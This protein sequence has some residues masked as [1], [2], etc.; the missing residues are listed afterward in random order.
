MPVDFQPESDQAI[1]FQPEETATAG[2]AALR[3]VTGPIPVPPEFDPTTLRKRY[4]GPYSGG[5]TSPYFPEQMQEAVS[6]IAAPYRAAGAVLGGI[7][8]DVS[9]LASDFLRRTGIN[10]AATAGEPM[11]NVPRIP[12]VPPLDVLAPKTG[13]AIEE[14]AGR[15]VSGFTEPGQAAL[16]PFA[17]LRP[18]QGLFG[19][20]AALQVPE[21]IQQL[22]Q[23]KGAPEVAG[24]TFEALANLGM[25]YGIGKHLAG[26][27]PPPA[28]G[29]E[30]DA[31][32][33]RGDK[34][35]GTQ[36][37]QEPQGSQAHRGGDVEQA[38]PG[39]T[40]PVETRKEGGPEVLLLNQASA[41]NR[42]L[43]IGHEVEVL[44]DFGPQDK[45]HIRVFRALPPNP[46][47]TPG[48]IQ[49]STAAF[50]KWLSKVPE[51]ERASAV[52]T[53]LAEEGI[54]STVTPEQ[55]L[56]YLQTLSPAEVALGKKLYLGDRTAEEAGLTPA[57]LGH[58]LL[59]QRLQR[60]L[61]MRPTELA[62]VA[63][64]ERWSRASLEFISRMIGKVRGLL[65]TDAAK[66]G[67]K[68]VNGLLDTYQRNIASLTGEKL[69]AA[70][71][72]DPH[73]GQV[74]AGQHHPAIMEALGKEGFE[75][76]ESRNTPDF[77]FSTNLRPFVSRTEAAGIAEGSGQKLE[78]FDVND[79]EQ[80]QPHSN[81]VA[82]PSDPEKP[83]SEQ[84][85]PPDT[86][87]EMP[88]LIRRKEDLP[89][90]I[91]GDKLVTVEREDG[92]RYVAA[93]GGKHWDLSFMGRGKVPSIAVPVNDSW[94]HGVLPKG[95]KV[96]E[97]GGESALKQAEERGGS[98]A[99][100]R[101]KADKEHP[102]LYLPPAGPEAA[103]GPRPGL[104]QATPDAVH[105]EGYGVLTQATDAATEEHLAGK[106]PSPPSFAEFSKQ[107]QLTFGEMN[108]AALA[109]AWA[110]T[111]WNRLQNASGETL[112][113]LRAALDMRH[114]LGTRDI[115]NPAHVPQRTPELSV[116]PGSFP[117]L[118]EEAR[119][120]REST[121]EARAMRIS[122]D[123]YRNNV[124]AQ[125]GEK[126]IA[127]SAKA[128]N[129]TRKEITPEDVA[130]GAKSVRPAFN[131]IGPDERANPGLLGTVLTDDARQM[132]IKVSATKRLTVLQN[133]STGKVEMVSTYRDP[134]RGAVLMDPDSPGRT[135]SPLASILK[136]WRPVVSVLLTEPVKDFQQSFSS[137][138]DFEDR[139]GSAA[140]SARQAGAN[141][142][143]PQT[144]F[145]PPQESPNA[146]ASRVPITEPEARA[147]LS[148]VLEEG[149]T[150][151]SPEDAKLALQSL[152]STT[153]K[154]RLAISGLKKL[155]A[156][157][158]AANP[159]ETAEGL[160]NKLAQT[161]YDNHKAATSTE[162]FQRRTMESGRPPTVP[163]PGAVPQ[164]AR[165]A[166]RA[167]DQA[168]QARIARALSGQGSEADVLEAAG[169]QSPADLDNVPAMIRRTAEATAQEVKLVY[170][171]V[172]DILRA[173]TVSHQ[174]SAAADAADNV[175][176]NT[177]RRAEFGIRLQSVHRPGSTLK[178]WFTAWQH[179]NPDVLAAA[180]VIVEAQGVMDSGAIHIG[181]VRAA[182]PGFR[183]KVA[184]GRAQA[185]VMAKSQSFRERRIG[186]AWLRACDQYDRELNYADA[187]LQDPDLKLTAGR[188]KLALDAQYNLERSAGY[189]LAKDPTYVPHR[190]DVELW[191]GRSIAFQ[192]GK[193]L[194]LKFR[195]AKRFKT[196]YDAIEQGPYL[197]VTR[198]SASLVS[199]RIR[200]GTQ[201]MLRDAWRK[202]LE[203]V[204]LPNGRPLAVRPVRRTATTWGSP[205]SAYVAIPQGGG[206][207]P[208]LI[209]HEDFESLIRNLTGR[210]VIHDWALTHGA[211]NIS[212]NLKHTL[213]MGD[214]FHLGR[215]VYYA[216]GIQ[217]TLTPKSKGAW[218]ALE[219]EPRDAADAIQRGVISRSDAAWAN[220]P[221]KFGSQ[222][223]NRRTLARMFESEAGLNIG[224]IQ[225]A[226]Y[227]DLATKLSP[228]AGPIRR[229]FVAVTDPSVGRYN[230]FLFDR[231]SRGLMLESAVRQF[232]EQ[233]KANPD[234]DPRLLMGDIA[235][236]VNVFFGNIGRQGWFKGAWQQDL[237]RMFLLAPQW[238]EGLIK[239]EAT[240]YT[241][242]GGTVA[243]AFGANY[244]QGLPALGTIGTGM[245]RGL[246]FMFALTQAVNLLTR[247]KPTWE[248]PE[249][250]HRFDAWIPGW[251]SDS[252][253]FWLSPLALFNEIT[254][255][256]YR[257]VEDKPKWT[258]AIDQIAGNKESP[259]VRGAI[260][261]WTSRSPTG[262]YLTTA[263]S[264]IG[265]TLEQL[266]PVP[267]TFS[268][269]A[270][271][272]AH[273]A[274]PG[275]VQANLPG[276]VQRQVFSTIGLKVEPARSPLQEAQ[277]LARDFA[278]SQKHFD[279]IHQEDTDQP[280]YSRLRSAVRAGDEAAAWKVLDQLRAH[281]KK[282]ADILKAMLA[283]RDRP[284]TWSRQAE[285]DF[286]YSLTPEQREVL[287]EATYQKMREY[288]AF[289]QMYQNQPAK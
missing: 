24:R 32:A 107:M 251:G 6:T 256:V 204:I 266:A 223:I 109:D 43:G 224:K 161:I 221:V 226:L 42:S 127:Q 280:S 202:G 76:R 56:A 112:G 252:S 126:L 242:Y 36:T 131:E 86:Q 89:P 58:E 33:I 261:F 174:V 206:A 236:D 147:V 90:L 175:A 60:I 272:L 82:S 55:A 148:K 238:V 96:I 244:R 25:G 247:R 248:N 40:Q 264:H 213:L 97:D 136:R 222:Q 120:Q 19:A 168:A 62:E 113:A 101:R 141:Y 201:M 77:G 92:S 45:E 159:N 208:P 22:Y 276:Q 122:A 47:G 289:L 273:M 123:R 241:R 283:W 98:P 279:P 199:H 275:L 196:H 246:L 191:S 15:L 179:G 121:K 220:E 212:Q 211:L 21:S 69:T 286:R 59:R 46:D 216:A 215:V 145:I 218:S 184:K 254:H 154:D 50:N 37:G 26:E 71:Y 185:E 160:L 249:K 245:G 130:Y 11:L 277:K 73:T 18:V 230:R 125:I 265:T 75:S 84:E 133:R 115:P 105:R 104:K 78:H 10:P 203:S 8:G 164:A 99:M 190:Y 80:P 108:P 231:L 237:A 83:L 172:R 197:P 102:E 186:K 173:G 263:G 253:G 111:V 234:V 217:R 278:E 146:W 250:E 85:T 193:F 38:A 195:E 39:P 88:F 287:A 91:P 119:Q 150:L 23:A 189:D 124:I 110:T 210:N 169:A 214:F 1:D 227:K 93:F 137:L 129:L 114:K 87:G 134:R 200:Q 70:A 128:Y 65:R 260:V 72:R 31:Q 20:Q 158:E 188:V 64:R 103:S 165:I 3:P 142:Q 233:S 267:I 177:A 52:Q 29:K 4:L 228:T 132:G 100:I 117:E 270:R 67:Q 225:D 268:R 49:M 187:H 240:S 155:A 95:E 13:Q 178:R 106:K 12:V 17:G 61:R 181:N 116:P 257:L 68:I 35:V 153:A 44:P 219:I 34:E 255:D 16:L 74:Y 9:E 239:K 54:H 229:G 143:A 170:E 269:Y 66:E 30:T 28:M 135:H 162:D 209:V 205:S 207:A 79:Q 167:A 176:N 149:R 198:D 14:A 48:K 243:R 63:G 232:E 288:Q 274:A 182:I 94:S 166:T 152:R 144:V 53:A 259:L 285:A 157:L 183:A 138:G 2:P 27:V 262:T 192:R 281:N 41:N 180:N 171:D 235:K 7:T 139:F 284:Y 5:P 151:D 271:G 118:V 81:E 258:D 57:N 163:A 194:G 156:R 282:D 51:K 140:R